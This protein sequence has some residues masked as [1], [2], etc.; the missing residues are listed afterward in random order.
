MLARQLKSGSNVLI[1]ALVVL[2]IIVAINFLASRRFVRADLT[3][4]K[5]YTISKS[6][7]KILKDLDD[8]VRLEAYFSK[9]PARVAQIRS[10]VKDM[11][12]EYGAFSKGNLQ[13]DFIDPVDFDETEKQ[14][15]RFMGIN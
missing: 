5:I 4:N 14:K 15:L 8:I 7:K 9:K 11:L 3:E 6:T 2:L 12:D 10:K 1:L 13:I